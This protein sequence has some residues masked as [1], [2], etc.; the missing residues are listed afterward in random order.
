M[1]MI[2][3]SDKFNM[4]CDIYFNVFTGLF[5]AVLL[6]GEFSNCYGQGPTVDSCITS[7]AIRVKQFRRSL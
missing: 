4:S 6:G 7:L 2:H 3:Y 5:Y 1:I